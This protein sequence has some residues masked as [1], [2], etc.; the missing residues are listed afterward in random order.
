MKGRRIEGVS[1]SRTDLESSI[2]SKPNS[3]CTNRS[4][5]KSRQ[6]HSSD[7]SDRSDGGW[8]I[9]IRRRKGKGFLELVPLYHARIE[10]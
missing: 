5:F 7:A 4:E 1:P 2:E 8:G 6:Y 3:V 10:F 9:E